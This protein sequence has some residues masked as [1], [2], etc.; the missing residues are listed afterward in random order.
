MEHNIKLS[1]YIF[2]YI[3]GDW[4]TKKKVMS[5]NFLWLTNEIDDP[6]DLKFEWDNT[7]FDG[8]YTNIEHKYIR[9]FI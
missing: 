8:F 1:M 5:L 7:K 4:R 2:N 3:F 9:L 6:V